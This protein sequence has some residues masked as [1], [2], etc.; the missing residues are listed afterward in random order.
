MIDNNDKEEM[1]RNLLSGRIEANLFRSRFIFIIGEIEVRLAKLVVGQLVALSHESS[2]D[3]IYILLSSPGGHVESGD[4]IHDMI[5]FI[6]S[7]VY[8]I[9]SG[10]VASAGTHIFLSVPKERRF[11]LENTRFLIHEPSGGIGGCA[12][13]IQIQAREILKMRDRLAKIISRETGQSFEKVRLDIDRDHWMSA[14]DAIEYGL[15]SRVIRH[16][17]DIR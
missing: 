13:D 2:H 12:T 4:L 5:K 11:C 9:G 3:P 6:D 14:Q 17:S 10:W 1:N 7:P 16:I 15:L 8:M